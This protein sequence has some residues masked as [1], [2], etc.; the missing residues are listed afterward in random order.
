MAW[1][2]GFRNLVIPGSFTCLSGMPF[3]HA[4]NTGCLKL[5]E[6]GWDWLFFLDSDVILP[7]DAIPRLMAHRKPI[8]SGLYYR[9]NNPICPVMLRNNPEGGRTWITEYKIPDLMEVDFVGS[10]CLLIHRDVIMA[11]KPVVGNTNCNRWF[12]WK[13]DREDLDPKERMSEDFSFCERARKELA[14]KIFVDT[15]VQC[16]HVGFSESKLPGQL[17]PLELM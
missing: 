5:L 13:V 1:A 17:T 8:V 16:K 14:V 2:V 12:E 15:S 7:H 10:G 3:G 4:R 11:M 6:L 9:R